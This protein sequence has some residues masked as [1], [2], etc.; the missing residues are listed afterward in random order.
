M[1]MYGGGNVTL[2]G[3]NNKYNQFGVEFTAI[4]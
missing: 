2:W 1:Y 4:G 3:V